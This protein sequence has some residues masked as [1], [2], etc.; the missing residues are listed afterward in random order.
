MRREGNRPRHHRIGRFF[1]S[2]IRRTGDPRAM[3]RNRKKGRDAVV[4]TKLHGP[5]Q[6]PTDQGAFLSVEFL[7]ERPIQK[8]PR[9]PGRP[10]WNALCR[11]SRLH[12]ESHTVR[13]VQD[14]FHRQ[15]DGCRRI[16][17]TRIPDRRPRDGGD[18][19]VPGIDRERTPVLR[20]MPVDRQADHRPQVGSDRNRGPGRDV[21]HCQPRTKRPGRGRCA[22]PGRGHPGT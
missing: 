19:P 1:R 17:R 2:R 11:I 14:R 18:R 22:S 13:L 12:S 9:I 7:V 21:T 8:G 16:G 6:C 10:E 5:H 3:P 15:Q 4:G 20:V